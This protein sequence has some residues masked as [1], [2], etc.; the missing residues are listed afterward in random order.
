MLFFFVLGWLVLQRMIEL[1]VAKRNEKWLAEKGAVQ[2]GSGHYLW[3][4]LLHGAF[5]LS[6]L[7]EVQGFGQNPHRYWTFLLFLFF[8]S[9]NNKNLD[10][11][12]VRP[13]L[14]YKN[15]RAERS[16]SDRK[17]TLPMVQ[18]S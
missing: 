14:E 17:R 5:F 8:L 12:F 13:L 9:S 11:Y 3:M 16:G 15:Y 4:V 2:F 10:Y 18:T 1:V 6:L 7:A